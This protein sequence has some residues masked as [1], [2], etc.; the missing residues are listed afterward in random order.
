[1]ICIGKNLPVKVTASVK[2][3]FRLSDRPLI[4]TNF[5][6]RDSIVDLPTDTDEDGVWSKLRTNSDGMLKAL[7]LSATARKN[8]SLHTNSVDPWMRHFNFR[9][10]LLWRWVTAYQCFGCVTN[11]VEVD[12][13]SSWSNSS[14]KCYYLLIQIKWYRWPS[15]WLRRN[16]SYRSCNQVKIFTMFLKYF[17]VKFLTVLSLR[18]GYFERKW[19]LTLSFPFSSMYLLM[20]ARSFGEYTVYV[21]RTLLDLDQPDLMH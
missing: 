6:T 8:S 11:N 1:M 5:A 15:S 3:M 13:T 17:L 9:E 14:E 10:P 19:R 12:N 16:L 21:V 7:I 20:S 18:F 2:V 4:G